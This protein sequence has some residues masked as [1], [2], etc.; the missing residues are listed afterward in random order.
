MSDRQLVTITNNDRRGI[1][2]RLR[3]GE[4]TGVGGHMQGCAGVE[5]PFSGLRT[6]R[7]DVDE[8]SAARRAW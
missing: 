1:E 3:G 4:G 7:W 5:E 8:A 6:E 2:E